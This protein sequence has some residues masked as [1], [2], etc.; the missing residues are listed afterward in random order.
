M[1]AEWIAIFPVIRSQLA[2]TRTFSIFLE[3]SRY[4][5]FTGYSNLLLT[6]KITLY[7]LRLDQGSKWS[8]A[9]DWEVWKFM[10]KVCQLN[11]A[12]FY[13]LIVEIRGLWYLPMA[14]NMGTNF[15]R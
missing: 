8:L 9:H 5:E 1:Y 12:R 6:V 7:F 3:D 11:D 14:K 15:N 2:V 4:R 13:K 10:V